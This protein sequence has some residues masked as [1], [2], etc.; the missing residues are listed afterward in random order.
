MLDHRLQI[1]LDEERYQRV[2]SLARARGVSVAAVVRDAIDR[3]L[4]STP[5]RR[6]AAL[7][8]I[9]AAPTMSVGPPDELRTELDE[10]RARRS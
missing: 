10:L 7:S 5:A 4:P 2:A 8:T 9:L 6:S 3:G 1:L